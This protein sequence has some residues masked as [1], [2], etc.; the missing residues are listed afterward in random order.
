MKILL[1]LCRAFF[2]DFTAP[3]GK[4]YPLEVGRDNA[5]LSEINPATQTAHKR[6]VYTKSGARCTLC[7]VVNIGLTISFTQIPLFPIFLYLLH[8]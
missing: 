4:H 8:K 2:F 1:M 6:G 5:I 7:W 3:N